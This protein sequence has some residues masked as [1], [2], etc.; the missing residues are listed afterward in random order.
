MSLTEEK[1]I[2]AVN[3]LAIGILEICEESR[4]LRDGQQIAS[5]LHRYTLV[6]GDDVT[7][8]PPIVASIAGAVW[9]PEV[10]AAYQQFIASQTAS[11][12]S[13]GNSSGIG[14]GISLG[15]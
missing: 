11:D 10:I 12:G 3:V 8:Q 4:I 9:T 14:I 15:L 13:G 5:I 2:A 6:P 1:V 7:G